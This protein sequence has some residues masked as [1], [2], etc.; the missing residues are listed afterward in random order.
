VTALRSIY[1]VARADFLERVRRYS[2]FLTVLFAVLLGYAAA[3][4]KLSIHLDDYRGVYTSAWI[5]TMVAMVTTCFVTLV[6]FY[7]VKNTIDRDR[8]TGVGQILAA[9]PLSKTSYALGKFLSNFTILSS[10]V[11]VL[12]IGAVLMRFWA[13]EDPHF[14]LAALLLPFLLLALPTMALTAAL[15]V[16]FETLPILRG[17]VGNVLWFFVFSFGIGLPG[18]TGR[19]W[20]D[21]MGLMTVGDSMMAAAR[22]SIP[23]YKNNFELT[24]DS[25][26]VRVAEAL[27]WE[28]V[29]W[30]SDQLLLRAACFAAAILITLLA[31]LF[32]DRFDPTR[33]LAPSIRTSRK[34]IR[35]E[36]A[37]GSTV[38]AGTL[39]S[40]SAVYLTPLASGAHT[41]AFG[42][43]FSAEFRLALKGF[44]WWWYVVA[45]G[46]LI[47]QIFVPLGP[48]QGILLG[49]AWIWP[50]LIWS[51][52]GTRESRFG[53]RGL[54]FSSP[55]ILLRQLPSCFL[56]GFA[57]AALAGAGVAVRLLI[58]GQFAG[59][60]AWFAGAFFLPSLAFASGIVSG[61][62]KVF[63]ALLTV[64]WYIGPMN[65]TPGFDFT[66]VA[67][68]SFTLRYAL[69][70]LLISVAL[71]A[72]AFFARARQLRSN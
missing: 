71:L 67:N 12:A 55:R 18:M 69:I 56:A 32:F 61:T 34:P 26:H 42:R 54:L 21:P 64:L 27:R 24:I 13:A 37:A 58:A 43:L 3:T 53:T 65:R 62:G 38:S 1:A 60:L 15:A 20:L 16:L 17:G 23:G 5:G 2:F 9:T 33:F 63:E 41:N 39:H 28:G 49:T 11:L 47:A 29:H 25:K 8:Q 52:M 50:I 46:L 7:I 31:A 68:G 45:A 72:G 30:T 70:Y 4:G 44:R 57:I 66:G 36:A 48:A 6:G 14:D 10:M 19:R 59:L 22:A 35:T 40:A 51:A